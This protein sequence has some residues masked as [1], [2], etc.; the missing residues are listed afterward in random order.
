M[1]LRYES[2][3]KKQS[4]RQVFE[5]FISIADAAAAVR[6]SKWTLWRKIRAG[7]IPA[8]GFRGA[9]RVRMSDVLQRHAPERYGTA[10]KRALAVDETCAY[11]SDGPAASVPRP[12]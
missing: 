8:F 10:R 1:D 4:N 3:R 9:L 6:M 12:T 2:D 5:P 11:R 7:E